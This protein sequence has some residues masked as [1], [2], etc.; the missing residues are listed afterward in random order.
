MQFKKWFNESKKYDF[1]DVR[2]MAKKG[3]LDIF[4]FEKQELVDGINIEQE[5][6]NSGKDVDVVKNHEEN[7]L[8]ITIAHLRED[9]HYYKKLRKAGI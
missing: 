8:K 6:K 3:G 4:P 2:R 9:P 1:N 5:H 7:I